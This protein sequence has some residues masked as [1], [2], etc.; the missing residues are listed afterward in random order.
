[1]RYDH[2]CSAQTADEDIDIFFHDVVMS[3]DNHLISLC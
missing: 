3:Y 2:L 1:M